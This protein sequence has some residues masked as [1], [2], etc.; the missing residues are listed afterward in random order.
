MGFLLHYPLHLIAQERDSWESIPCSFVLP[1]GNTRESPTR[2][3][4][5]QLS[6]RIILS[7]EMGHRVLR[8]Q[9]RR[10]TPKLGGVLP[11]HLHALA[12]D[13]NAFTILFVIFAEL[14]YHLKE[15]CE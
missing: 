2:T 15:Q 5:L 4:P 14:S 1:T 9:T 12:R 3:L 13:E 11:F 10:R 8:E 7:S 6:G